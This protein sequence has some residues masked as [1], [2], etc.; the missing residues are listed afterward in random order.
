MLDGKWAK[1]DE[2]RQ[3]GSRRILE[4]MKLVEEEAPGLID[5]A[6]FAAAEFQKSSAD[7]GRVPE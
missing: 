1:L 4:A 3:P 6:W 7:G 2:L 5:R